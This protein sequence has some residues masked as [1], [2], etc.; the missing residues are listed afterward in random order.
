LRTVE[1]AAEDISRAVIDE[2][3]IH[4]SESTFFIFKHHTS[5]KRVRPD[6]LNENMAAI[7][8]Q[9]FLGVSLKDWIKN[10]RKAGIEELVVIYLQAIWDG[11]ERRHFTLWTITL[12]KQY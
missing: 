11:R 3:G 12:Y 2:I 10:A 5:G 7:Y 1:L 8:G 9:D 4:A 6:E